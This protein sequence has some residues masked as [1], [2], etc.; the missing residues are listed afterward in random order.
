MTLTPVT[1]VVVVAVCFIAAAVLTGVAVL[2]VQ[3]GRAS[4]GRFL[5]GMAVGLAAAAVLIAVG[6]AVS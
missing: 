5:L 1:A 2:A 6:G 3:D 4:R